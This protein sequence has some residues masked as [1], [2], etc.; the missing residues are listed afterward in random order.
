MHQRF[1]HE[2]TSTRSTG[3]VIRFFSVIG[4][5]LLLLIAWYFAMVR[6]GQ[7][8]VVVTGES[9]DGR[10]YCIV[11][12]YRDLIEPYQVS[13][14][15]RDSAGSWRWHY[16]EHED[17]AW[18]SARVEFQ[19]AQVVV[20]RN[21]ER[22]REIELDREAIEKVTPELTRKERA[23]PAELSV[24]EVARLHHVRYGND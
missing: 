19:G 5:L 2:F 13:L 17:N 1:F 12:T 22:F 15:V 24:N 11:Q 20:Y 21:S 8:G 10:E 16:L 9:Q 4:I 6:P 14:Y 3:G 18:R 23:L 7:S